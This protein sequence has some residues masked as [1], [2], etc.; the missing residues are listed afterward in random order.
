MSGTR[1]N[2]KVED[3]ASSITVI[4]KEQMSDFALLDRHR[5]V[6]SARVDSFDGY[7]SSPDL[8]RVLLKNVLAVRGSAVVQHDGF[9]RKPSG[10]D[11]RRYQGMVKHQPFKQTTL[12]A[13]FSYYKNE[14]NRPNTT[15]PRDAVTGWRNA[16]SP[17]WDPVTSRV[18]VN[19]VPGTAA[20]GIGALPRGLLNTVGTGRTISTMFVDGDGT[21]G[22]WGATQGSSTTNPATR[23][24][25]VF[26]VNSRQPEHQL[27]ARRTHRSER[28]EA[29]HRRRRPAVGGQGRD[30]LIR[31]A[32][33]PRDCHGPRSQ[34]PRLGQSP[35]LRRFVPVLPHA[36]LRRQSRHHL[37]T[38][39][40]QPAGRRPP[41][42]HQR[43]SQRTRQRFPY[44]RSTAVHPD[45]DV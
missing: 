15:T 6:L 38:Q 12:S 18:T 30:R 7:R 4:T 32:T 37:S 36:P 35:A 9:D 40:A 39:R 14:G 3:L 8:N 34:P 16:G 10:T 22:W 44:H 26:L 20:I 23:D 42:T 29:L 45:R 5:S 11:T 1:L 17:L 25:A 21:V 28:S 2:S 27:P 33:A 13:S 41:P 31:P 43:V 19:G 24:V